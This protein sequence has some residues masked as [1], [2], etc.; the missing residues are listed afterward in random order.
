MA[1]VGAGKMG[2]LHAAILGALPGVRVVAIC[3]KQG[4]VRR[5]AKTALPGVT[6]LDDVLGIAPGDVDAVYVATLP[7]SHH[8]IVKAIYA[9][10]ITPNIFV[11]KSLAGNHEQAVEMCHLAET[12]AGVTMVGFQKRFSAT[13]GKAMELLAEGALGTVTSFD[14]HAYSS[15]FVEAGADMS[16]AASRGGVLRDVGSHVIDLAHWYFGD[17]DVMAQGEDSGATALPSDG[18]FTSVRTAGGVTGTFRVSAQMP[19]YRL[20]ETAMRAT[21][22]EGVLT[23]NDDMIE[24]EVPSRPQRWY[25]QDLADNRVPFVLGEAE[26]SREALAFVAAVMN[27]GDHGGADFRAGARVERVIDGIADG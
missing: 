9:R 13:F 1:I 2:V 14:A 16:Q 23:V 11:E 27:G 5:F 22:T 8:S 4:I 10:G 26:Y 18:C 6:V 7:G 12:H 21:G 24:L 20:P 17:L 19:A 15:D 3:E 25:R